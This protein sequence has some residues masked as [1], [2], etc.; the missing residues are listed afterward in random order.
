MFKIRYLTAALALSL[1]FLPGLS[2]A[3][4]SLTGTIVRVFSY[5]DAYGSTNYIYFRT[6][7][8]ASFYYYV[9]TTDDDMAINANSH[10]NSGRTLTFNGNVAS[11]PAVPAAGGSASIGSL[12]Y[13]YNP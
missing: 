13:F 10:L 11:C 4:C 5:D 3:S 1:G 6:S 8:L 2:Q 7:S 12:N 9:T